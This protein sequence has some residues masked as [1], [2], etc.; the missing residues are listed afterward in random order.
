MRLNVLLGTGNALQ[1]TIRQGGGRLV[2]WSVLVRVCACERARVC[3]RVC[4]CMCQC[5]YKY[6]C[7]CQSV[8]VSVFVCVR[9]RVYEHVYVHGYVRTHMY[10]RLYLRVPSPFLKSFGLPVQL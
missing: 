9:V 5:V 7:M 8:P 2:H 4:A 3:A 1:Q 10:L 6:Q